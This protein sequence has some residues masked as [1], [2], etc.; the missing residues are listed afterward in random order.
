MSLA[1]YK[2]RMKRHIS[3]NHECSICEKLFDLKSGE[4]EID[5]PNLKIKEEPVDI[6]E[7]CLD[8]SNL[9]RHIDKKTVRRQGI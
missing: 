5:S 6:K 2:E 7:E 1:G 3:A 8:Q 4:K 9:L